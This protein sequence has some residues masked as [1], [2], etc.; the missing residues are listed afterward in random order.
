MVALIAKHQDPTASSVSNRCRSVVLG[1]LYIGGERRAVATSTAAWIDG[2]RLISPISAPS[3][4]C[5]DK[6]GDLVRHRRT[7]ISKFRTS[8]YDQVKVRGFRIEP[9]E[10]EAAGAA[11]GGFSGGGRG[12]RMNSA[13]TA[14]VV[15]CDVLQRQPPMEASCAAS[16]QQWL[17]DHMLPSAF[18]RLAGCRSRPAVRW[19]AGVFRTRHGDS[20]REQV[21]VAL[22]SP[23]EAMSAGIWG[24]LL[25]LERRSLT[26]TS[27]LG[28]DFLVATSISAR[29]EREFEFA[30]ECAASSGRHGRRPGCHAST[31]RLA[32]QLDLD[33]ETRLLGRAG[34]GGNRRAL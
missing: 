10:I 17:P 19:I 1:Q 34:G 26:M 29:A 11:P 2:G 12:T 16:L 8:L 23:M 13:G 14:V 30:A 25:R 24:E 18:V 15:R 3:R 22:G 9:G 33:E 6:T 21:S 27:L 4:A 7:V 20:E 31:Q 32:E 28:G 5:V